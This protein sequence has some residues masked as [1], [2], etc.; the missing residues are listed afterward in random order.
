MTRDDHNT[1]MGVSYRPVVTQVQIA[2]TSEIVERLA[3]ISGW[4]NTVMYVT[5]ILR[6]CDKIHMKFFLL[7]E[8]FFIITTT[9]RRCCSFPRTSIGSSDGICRKGHFSYA[10]NG[11]F[12]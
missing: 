5:R 12:S 7:K 8:M 6:A 4:R 9:G 10:S 1:D 11:M 2:S 3:G